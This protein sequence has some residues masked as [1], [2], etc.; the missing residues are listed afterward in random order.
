MNV[1]PIIYTKVAISFLAIYNSSFAKGLSVYVEDA[2]PTPVDGYCEG[3]DE[4][5]T[6]FAG[7]GLNTNGLILDAA[8]YAVFNSPQSI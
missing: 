4:S 3:V 8:S 7:V 1:S 5:G 6:L 2:I